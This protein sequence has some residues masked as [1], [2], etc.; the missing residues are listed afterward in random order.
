[1]KVTLPASGQAKAKTASTTL[2]FDIYTADS[3]DLVATANLLKSQ[4]GAIGARIDIQVFNQADL[5][6]NIITTRKYD[7]LLFG[8]QIGKD[9]DLYAFWHSSQRNA[10]GLNVSLYANSKADAIL[11]DIR[12]NAST[13]ALSSDYA[14]L[15]SLI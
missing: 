2:S 11:A 3:P 15:D 9:R 4:W 1:K 14:K 10:P 13:T 7:V 5:Y 6:Q 8:E 12:S